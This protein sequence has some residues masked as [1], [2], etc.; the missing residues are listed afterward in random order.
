LVAL[1]GSLVAE[2]AV[3]VHHVVGQGGQVIPQG[4]VVGVDPHG[5][6]GVFQTPEFGPMPTLDAYEAKAAEDQAAHQPGRPRAPHFCRFRTRG[7]CRGMRPLRVFQHLL[8]TGHKLWSPILS[9]TRGPSFV[10]ASCAGIDPGGVQWA[11][12]PVHLSMSARQGI[13]HS[14]PTNVSQDRPSSA[15]IGLDRPQAG[16]DLA[17]ALRLVPA[18][19]DYESVG[20]AVDAVHRCRPKRRSPSEHSS[21]QVLDGHSYG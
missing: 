9:V 7:T 3:Q 14:G 18:D 17:A 21:D 15:A 4:L 2:R 16:A 10:E 6:G 5:Q 12:L 11:L 13:G 19:E 20:R 1:D 8:H